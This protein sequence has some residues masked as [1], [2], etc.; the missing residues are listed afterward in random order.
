MSI[1]FNHLKTYRKYE[2]KCLEQTF[3]RKT[4]MCYCLCVKNDGCLWVKCLTILYRLSFALVYGVSIFWE[5]CGNTSWVF[6]CW[7]S[8]R[9]TVILKDSSSWCT[10]VVRR[11]RCPLS[12]F[13]S[14]CSTEFPCVRYKQWSYKPQFMIQTLTTSTNTLLYIIL[15]GEIAV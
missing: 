13:I 4:I 11:Q 9:R 8:Q 2:T 10:T 12:L 7:R 14:F 3:S 1:L 5:Q 6:I 15:K